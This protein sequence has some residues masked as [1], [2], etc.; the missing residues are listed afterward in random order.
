VMVCTHEHTYCINVC[1]FPFSSFQELKFDVM[2]FKLKADFKE[3]EVIGGNTRSMSS[4]T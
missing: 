4:S 2:L 1:K 3:T